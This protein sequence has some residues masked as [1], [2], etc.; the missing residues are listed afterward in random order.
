MKN[1]NFKLG[2]FLPII[3]ISLPLI[4]ASCKTNCDNLVKL[5]LKEKDQLEE[6]HSAKYPTNLLYLNLYA[7]TFAQFIDLYENNSIR[8]YKYIS[9]S[10]TIINKLLKDD[11]KE[12]NGLLNILNLINSY[13]NYLN[14]KQGSLDFEE[15][16]NNIYYPSL[17]KTNDKYSEILI[18][19]I[20]KSGNFF[21]KYKYDRISWT[22]FD[23]FRL[24]WDILINLKET[25]HYYYLVL[26]YPRLVLKWYMES[27]DGDSRIKEV[28]KSIKEIFD[29]TIVN[30]GE[31]EIKDINKINEIIKQID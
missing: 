21:N 2:I 26:F 30:K 20:E 17:S 15:I 6:F 29:K 25:K 7:I 11:P 27:D 24:I 13:E 4:A 8:N 12:Q 18:L 19:L 28:A 23:V 10:K 9:E 22:H 14:N 1:K 3:F 31:L 5:K 16:I